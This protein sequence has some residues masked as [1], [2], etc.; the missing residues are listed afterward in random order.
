[1]PSPQKR[2][3]LTLSSVWRTALE[4]HLVSD[5]RKGYPITGIKI[6]IYAAQNCRQINQETDQILKC[7]KLDQVRRSTRMRTSFG[8]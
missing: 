6:F 1:M 5:R 7:V 8:K 2:S 4:A 3:Y